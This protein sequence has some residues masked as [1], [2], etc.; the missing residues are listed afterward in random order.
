LAFFFLNDRTIGT[1]E[2][3]GMLNAWKEWNSASILMIPSGEKEKKR[4]SGGMKEKKAFLFSIFL[5]KG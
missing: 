5:R 2:F 3:I 4:L 1:L